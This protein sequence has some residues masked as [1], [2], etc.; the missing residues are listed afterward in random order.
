MCVLRSPVK[1]FVQFMFDS[2]QPF[3]QVL[4]TSVVFAARKQINAR[5]L[6]PFHTVGKRIN[7]S[8]QESVHDSP[9]P[10]PSGNSKSKCNPTVTLQNYFPPPNIPVN[11][12]ITPF[13]DTLNVCGLPAAPS[14]IVKT[15]DSAPCAEGAKIT[16]IEHEELGATPPTQLSVSVKSA[17]CPG[18]KVAVML[19]T[20]RVDV[21]GFKTVTVCPT[22]FP[23]TVLA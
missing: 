14:I 10:N 21:P 2:F 23:C 19:V 18:G 3:F 13:P 5:F 20:V 4:V 16:K 15:A 17:G 12:T 22:A 9:G 1:L 11:A 8:P 7:L 6:Q